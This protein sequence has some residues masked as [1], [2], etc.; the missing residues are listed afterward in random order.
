MGQTNL[1]GSSLLGG[2]F[3][4]GG[5]GMSKFLASGRR[6]PPPPI[7]QYRENCEYGYT[8]QLE[9]LFEKEMC[10]FKQLMGPDPKSNS[11]SICFDNDVIL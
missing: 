1:C 3:P 11:V 9:K 4:S 8:R 10:F 6:T 2:I 7:L 5:W